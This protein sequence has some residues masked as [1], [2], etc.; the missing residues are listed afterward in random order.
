MD[1]LGADAVAVLP[2]ARR[3]TLAR[4][5]LVSGFDEAMYEAVLRVPESPRLVDLLRART[6]EPQPG[7]PGDYQ[8]A[9]S[10][11]EAAWRSWW[12][13]GADQSGVP[14]DLREFAAGVARYCQDTR[15]PVEALRA[16][17]IADEEEAA[18]WFDRLY[19]QRDAD[20]DLAGCA[21]LLDV[22]YELSR[23]EHAP[24]LGPALVPL[25]N[26]RTRYLNA[27]CHWHGAQLASSRYLSRPGVEAPLLDLLRAEPATR[28]LRLHGSSGMGKSKTLH[29][30][31][32]HRCVPEPRR[33]PCALIDLGAVDP[34]NA[35]RHPWLV[36]LEIAGQL[37]VQMEGAPFQELLRQHGVAR[38]LLKPT[39]EDLARSGAV[40]V[41]SAAA[42]VEAED[43]VFRFFSAL[44]EDT[45]RTP[46]VVAVDTFEDAVL[47]GTD[48][49]D[50]VRLLT[51]LHDASARVRLILSGRLTGEEERCLRCASACP[52]RSWRT[53]GCRSSAPPRPA[54][55]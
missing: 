55:T 6:F 32:A 11:R 26:D 15:R 39:Q 12:P 33:V 44:V 31:I 10:L 52:A 28:A 24:P 4:C 54:S 7:V 48:P 19:R 2:A 41:D 50:I 45:S 23:P 27:R 18:G 35:T 43:V 3:A 25:R 36:L 49:A 51:D 20:L 13:E 37:N 29:W 1:E 46:V 14:Q 38:E 16:L 47:K 42:P 40:A 53:W 22:L 21:D 9:L 17:A 5:A 34:I 30:L 8:V